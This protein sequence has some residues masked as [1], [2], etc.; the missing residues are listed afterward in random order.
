MMFVK[1]SLISWDAALPVAMF[2]RHTEK[3]TSSEKQS[4][5]FVTELY[6]GHCCNCPLQSCLHVAVLPVVPLLLIL[7][8]S[9]HYRHSTW[10]RCDTPS[11][12]SIV[13]MAKS[14]NSS[15]WWGSISIDSL[16]QC[17]IYCRLCKIFSRVSRVKRPQLAVLP[18]FLDLPCLVA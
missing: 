4:D 16:L 2:K 11:S 17:W 15:H 14:N 12:D 18:D 1:Y 6:D 8:F 9:G 10:G 5:E 3:E 13:E 7:L